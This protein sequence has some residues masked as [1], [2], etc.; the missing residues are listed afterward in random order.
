LKNTFKIFLVFLVA[1]YNISCNSSTQKEE[2]QTS[3]GNDSINKNVAENTK[4]QNIMRI[5]ILYFKTSKCI[6]LGFLPKLLKVNFTTARPLE[7]ES[8]YFCVAGA[9]TSKIKNVDGLTIENGK[10]KTSSVNKS[11]N[12]FVK[13]ENR[14]ITFY[15]FNNTLIEEVANEVVKEKGSLFQQQLLIYDNRVVD[16]KLFGN[17]INIR[18]AL[19]EMNGTY[20]V[21]QSI[22]NITIQDFQI[23]LQEIEVKN[24][25][26]LDMGSYSEGWFI[27]NAGKKQLLGDNFANTKNQTNWISFEK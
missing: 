19:L 20:L 7:S 4:G 11:L 6:L 8:A 25:I 23:A 12:G 17:K 15:Q 16:C 13:I 5:E 26:Y 21:M 24:A 2:S 1:L 27:D 14:E 18:R 9:F 22:E 10:K 3:E